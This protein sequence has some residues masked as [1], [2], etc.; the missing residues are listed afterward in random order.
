MKRRNFV[1]GALAAGA[2][3]G[4]DSGWLRTLAAQSTPMMREQPVNGAN[5]KRVLVVFKCHLDLGFID[6]QANVIRKYFEV[7]YPHALKV[8]A[9]MRASGSDRYVWSTGSWLL[10]EYLEQAKP[11]ARKQMEKAVTDGDIAWHALP[12][13]WQTELMDRSM[14]EGSPWPIA[15]ARSP[16]QPHHDRRQDDRRPRPY[17]RP[18]RTSGR[19]RRQTPRHRRQRRQHCAGSA[20]RSFSGK[21]QMEPR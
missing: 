2:V 20:C 5:T 3:F 4:C 14:I 11:D 10:Y 19:T 13:T 16:L 6:T 21:I 15:L 9:E 18:D 8:T 7:Y 12:F 1:R 17:A